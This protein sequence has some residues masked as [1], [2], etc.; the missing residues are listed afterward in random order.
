MNALPKTKVDLSAITGKYPL[1]ALFL[2][3]TE[4]L[5]GLWLFL[6]ESIA[7][8]TT[9][10]ALM[11]LMFAGFLFVIL[12][13]SKEPKGQGDAIA[14]ESLGKI[15]PASQ[16]VTKAEIEAA[17]PKV[18]VAPDRSYIIDRPPD[19]WITEE[20]TISEWASRS[21]GVSDAQAKLHLGLGQT[22]ENNDVLLFES[23]TQISVIPIPGKT[24]I[25]GR[26]LPSALE[27]LIPTRLSIIPI[28]RAQPPFYFEFPLLQNFLLFI[29]E[30]V[31]SGLIPI[32]ELSSGMTENSGR[33]YR[34]AEFHQ[35]VEHA[36]INGE[37]S[38]GIR[39]NITVIGIEGEIRDYL[40]LMNY[41]SQPTG[42]DPQ[43]QRD[44]EIIRSLVN[45][46]KP[47]EAINPDR[48][49]RELQTLAAQNFES[50]L[51]KTGEQM[52][53]A[54]FGL[55]IL[56]LISTNLD[57]PYERLRAAKLL[58]PFEIFAQQINYHDDDLDKL[59]DALHE[60]E[61]GNSQELRNLLIELIEDFKE[62]GKESDAQLSHESNGAESSPVESTGNNT[63]PSLEG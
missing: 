40:L 21:L 15:S 20:L 33:N 56:R 52:F 58:K 17:E 57:D 4:A 41:T 31:K 8:R 32:R 2:L 47:L 12:Q 48:K 45:S 44:L 14:L 24:I 9:A 25:N 62:R 37:E 51:Q 3:V 13:I 55:L 60:A 22:E 5:L 39:S 50:M 30:I 59:W 16:E 49:R 1:L 7:E 53:Y 11:V 23:P 61:K 35:D 10:G 34:L 28:D 54:E 26:K 38:K 46:F 63:S 43:V 29:S 27:V 19:G 6:A 42:G 18:L 36:I